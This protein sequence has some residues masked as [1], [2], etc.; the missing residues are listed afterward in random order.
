MSIKDRD[1]EIVWLLCEDIDDL[2]YDPLTVVHGSNHR[3]IS[4]LAPG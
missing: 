2:K 1:R 3:F 4:T